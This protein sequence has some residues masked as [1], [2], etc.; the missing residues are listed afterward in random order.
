[1]SLERLQCIRDELEARA[2]GSHAYNRGTAEQKSCGGPSHHQLASCL[3]HRR[4]LGRA[5]PFWG[6]AGYKSMHSKLEL[7]AL[8]TANQVAQISADPSLGGL[9]PRLPGSKARHVLCRKQ[10]SVAL[11]PGLMRA[12]FLGREHLTHQSSSTAL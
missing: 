9:L 2:V 1:M 6:L 8:S 5:G 10:T 3:P 7:W 11:G 12:R 4:A